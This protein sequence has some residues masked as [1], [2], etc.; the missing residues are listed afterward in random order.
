[1]IPSYSE[2]F[3]GIDVFKTGDIS[4]QMSGLMLPLIIGI[5]MQALLPDEIKHSDV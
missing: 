4:F 2:I 1:L 3:V 5:L